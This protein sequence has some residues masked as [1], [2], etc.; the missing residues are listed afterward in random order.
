LENHE[1]FMAGRKGSGGRGRRKKGGQKK[2]PKKTK[3]QLYVEGKQKQAIGKIS[4]TLHA[5]Q[6]RVLTDLILGEKVSFDSIA[7]AV[8]LGGLDFNTVLEAEYVQQKSLQALFLIRS[9]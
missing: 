9:V 7:N 4:R 5:R 8:K 3:A 2:K 6:K 1:L